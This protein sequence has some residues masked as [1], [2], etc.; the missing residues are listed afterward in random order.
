MVNR[1]LDVSAQR[2]FGTDEFAPQ[3]GR[4]RVGVLIASTTRVGA[5]GHLSF[6]A[7][8]KDQGVWLASSSLLGHSF[9]A[10]LLPLA[11]VCSSACDHRSRS[12][13]AASAVLSGGWLQ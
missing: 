13:C 8:L 5:N 7:A 6:G 1:R 10:S 9:V 11:R 12:Y 4:R 2:R 3:H